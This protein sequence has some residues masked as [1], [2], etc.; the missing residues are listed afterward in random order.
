M[1]EPTCPSV[2]RTISPN[3]EYLKL[4]CRRP[5]KPSLVPS[6]P[7]SVG[8]T[9]LSSC[10]RASNLQIL[11]DPLHLPFPP[12][13]TRVR[14]SRSDS[15]SFSHS[16]L[17]RILAAGPTPHCQMRL[18]TLLLSSH[19]CLLPEPPV[20]SLD[21]RNLC[22]PFSVLA[23]PS[24]F[25]LPQFQTVCPVA[26]SFC[27]LFMPACPPL[28][29]SSPYPVCPSGPSQSHVFPEALPLSPRWSVL[30]LCWSASVHVAVHIP[31]RVPPCALLPCL[32]Q[33]CLNDGIDEAGISHI[34]LSSSGKCHHLF[35]KIWQF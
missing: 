31:H 8:G 27:S 23:H 29:F 3:S 6:I 33:L 9:R 4:C 7:V 20:N 25:L 26:F 18:S 5:P 22:L 12:L 14:H 1:I 15:F 30:T 34:N 10:S 19:P 28:L 24:L 2:L 21:L 11:L 32:P 13:N 17:P 16:V 35:P